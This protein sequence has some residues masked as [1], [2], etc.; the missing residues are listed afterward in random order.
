MIA[1]LMVPQDL[2]CKPV[3]GH[4]SARRALVRLAPL[5]L[6]VV[7][8]HPWPAS[9]PCQLTVG[10]QQAWPGKS[11]GCHCATKEDDG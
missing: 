7:L 5:S 8:N 2:V 3:A 4:F 9:T 1:L 11:S 10:F 6:I